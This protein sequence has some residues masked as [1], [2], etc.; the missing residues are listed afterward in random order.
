M[1]PHVSNKDLQ[2]VIDFDNSAS[3]E[4]SERGKNIQN[5]N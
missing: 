1:S 3:F 2:H 5:L 4:Q